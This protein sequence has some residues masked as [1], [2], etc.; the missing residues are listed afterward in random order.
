[1]TVEI[2]INTVIRIICVFGYQAMAVVGGA[3]IID[4]SIS[5]ATAAMLAG[6]SAVAQVMQKLAAAFVDDGK[7]DME[8]INAAFSG[9]TKNTNS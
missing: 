6:I 2:A 3:S 7:L 9:T 5:P 1:M 8:E 4:S